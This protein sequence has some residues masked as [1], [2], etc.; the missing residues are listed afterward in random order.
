[1]AILTSI[2]HPLRIDSVPV[3]LGE[4]GLTFCPG[5]KIQGR[6]GLW[7]RDIE[8]DIEAIKEWEPDS[9]ISLLE[10]HEYIEMQVPELPE[11]F[12]REFPVWYNLPIKDKHAPDAEWIKAW[13]LIR[14]NIFHQVYGGGKIL[15]HCKGGFGRT[16]TVAALILMECGHHAEDAIAECRAARSGAIENDVQENFLLNYL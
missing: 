7:M 5:K 10:P 11:I 8:L 14:K 16:G 4:L 12:K 2:D 9:I 3:G 13:A 1:M 6:T 15:I